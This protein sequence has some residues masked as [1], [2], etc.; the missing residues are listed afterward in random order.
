MSNHSPDSPGARGIWVRALY[1]LLFVLIYNIAEI[2]VLFV[3][4]FQFVC[5]LASGARNARV[6]ELGQG[7]SRYVY[8]IFLFL[9]FNSERLP[10]PFDE[11]PPAGTRPD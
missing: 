1:M 6:L 9:T 10:F 11:W 2:V 8:E 7:L 5:V 4:V 3:V